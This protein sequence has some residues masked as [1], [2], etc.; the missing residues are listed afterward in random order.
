MGATAVV[1]NTYNKCT[2]L[3][4]HVLVFPSDD[5]A[6]QGRVTGLEELPQFVERML[7]GR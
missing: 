7:V 1:K 6:T 5:T 4:E 2:K 3:E